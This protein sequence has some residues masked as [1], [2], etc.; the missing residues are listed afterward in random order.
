MSER[1]RARKPSAR[2]GHVWVTTTPSGFYWRCMHCP[3]EFGGGRYVERN[4]DWYHGDRPTD[5]P[6]CDTNQGR[7]DEMP[8]PLTRAAKRYAMIF[9][10]MAAA[11]CANSE[12]IFE[13][14]KGVAKS[15]DSVTA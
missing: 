10:L 6:P 2:R 14:R 12:A 1:E 11:I 9:A 3:A 7:L 15:G 13:Q 8:P 4:A 5:E